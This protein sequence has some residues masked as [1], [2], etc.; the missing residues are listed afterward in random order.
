V[1]M[2]GWSLPARVPRLEPG[3]EVKTFRHEA[4]GGMYSASRRS[5]MSIRP[6]KYMLFAPVLALLILGHGLAGKLDEYDTGKYGISSC[7]P[8]GQ[9][10]QIRSQVNYDPNLSDL[11]FESEKW[12][13]SAWND[14][15]LNGRMVA[16][17]EACPSEEKRLPCRKNTARCLISDGFEH[18]IDFCHAKLLDD[19][20]TIELLIHDDSSPIDEYLGIIV[21]EGSFWSQYWLTLKVAK[22]YDGVLTEGDVIWTTQKQQLTLDNQTYRKGDTIK[23]RIVFECIQEATHPKWV[24]EYGKNPI[25]IRIEGVFKTIVE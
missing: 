18:T 23:G 13:H 3:N 10:T 22:M 15:E 24:E 7:I 12:T 2:G 6:L 19:G 16:T 5:S 14:E 21:R 17:R 11:F 20:K 1:L 9:P 25:T 4:V 8:E